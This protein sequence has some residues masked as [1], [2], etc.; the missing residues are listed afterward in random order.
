MVLLRDGQTRMQC[1]FYKDTYNVKEE[2][3]RRSRWQRRT[4]R[5]R[6]QEGTDRHTEDMTA[7]RHQSGMSTNVLAWSGQVVLPKAFFSTILLTAHSTVTY[8]IKCLYKKT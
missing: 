6:I 5:I 1:G 2:L 4:S 3:T 7:V 8:L